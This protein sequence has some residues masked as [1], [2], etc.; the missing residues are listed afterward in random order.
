MNWDVVIGLEV[1]AQLQTQSKLFS[2]APNAAGE[3]PNE[4]ASAVELGLPGTLPVLNREALRL[5]LR[6]GAAID[7][8]LARE[9][10]FARKNYFYP[11]L[12]KGYQISQLDAPI[13]GR[14]QLTVVMPDGTSRAIAITRAHLEE[15][16]GKSIHDA[17][18]GSTAID[19][20]R[21]GTPLL[22]IVSEPELH[23]AGEAVAY[24][25]ELHGLVRTLG[26]CDGNMNEGSLRC[27]ANVSLKPAG[28]STL[29]T[30]TEIKNLNS[31]RFLE[32]A[33]TYEIARQQ[34]VL[35]GGGQVVQET[36]LYDP[37]RDETRPM[38]SKEEAE[39]YRYFPDPDLLPLRLTEADHAEARATLPE[40]PA[41][42]RAR[43]EETFGLSAGDARLLAA[44]RATAAYFEAALA[45]GAPAKAAANWLTG[46]IAAYL[47]REGVNLE[48][49]P[50][51]PEA[52]AGL[53]ARVE[54]GT[55]SSKL[56]KTVFER[57]LER[58]EAAD[59]I[60]EQDGLKQVSDTGALDALVQ[61]VIAEN[62]EQV[63]QF[64]AGKGKVLGFFVGQLMKASGGKANPQQLNS[65][66]KAALGE[67][68]DA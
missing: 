65:L 4:T 12:P 10:V 20:N 21:A 34:A 42:K 19:L 67:P 27:D 45:A 43:Y 24:L 63:A 62:P 52:L 51:A 9:T 22:E 54:D 59:L 56:A 33:I 5:A 13:V 1:H 16:A 37:D 23:S 55:L 60:I 8:E 30:R 15:D 25:R 39:D 68:G 35:E 3:T 48:A 29:G 26:I 38:R 61:K 64:R 58:G 7:A 36:R 49:F 28:S 46:E 32:R 14:G 31:F 47:N 66:L 50:L 2:S 18:A 44:D 53:I 11:D 57:M 17:Y 41:A 6:F 40:L